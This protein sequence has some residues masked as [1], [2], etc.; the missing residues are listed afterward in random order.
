MSYLKDA[1]CYHCLLK[2][3]LKQYLSHPFI[4]PEVILGR[5]FE[6]KT[7][8]SSM[9]S[10]ALKQPPLHGKRRTLNET[11]LNPCNLSTNSFLNIYPCLFSFCTH[12]LGRDSVS[13]LCEPW[14]LTGAEPLQPLSSGALEH[15]RQA[16]TQAT[17]M[18][19][20]SLQLISAMKAA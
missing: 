8:R 7:V 9:S 4:S 20:L 13:A 19:L 15:R 1:T 12:F 18:S 17:H 10:E 6:G 2:I 5:S 14:G 11:G 3:M 16:L